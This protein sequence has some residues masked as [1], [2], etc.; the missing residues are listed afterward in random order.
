MT[1]TP[2]GIRYVV[3]LPAGVAA[4]IAFD[5]L[6]SELGNGWLDVT[7]RIDQA[8]PAAWLQIVLD[9]DQRGDELLHDAGRKVFRPDRVGDLIRKPTGRQAAPYVYLINGGRAWYAAERLAVVESL[10]R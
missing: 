9:G 4:A 10:T 3:K 8:D 6:G 2:I 7:R 5:G 1:T